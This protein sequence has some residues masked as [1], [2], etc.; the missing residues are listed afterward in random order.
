MVNRKKPSADQPN[1]E[2]LFDMA[3]DTAKKGNRS[4]ARL[5][6]GQILQEDP[7]NIRAMMW[8]AKLSSKPEERVKW[9]KR[10]LEIKPNYAQARQELEKIAH[11]TQAQRNSQLLRFGTIGYAVGLALISALWILS[12]ALQYR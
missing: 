11:T 9:L 10:V 12:T 7:R 8:M 1:R 4:G 6:F 2:V 3:V 5:M